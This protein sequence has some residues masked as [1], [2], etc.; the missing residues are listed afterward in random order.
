MSDGSRLARYERQDQYDDMNSDFAETDA[1]ERV[2]ASSSTVSSVISCAAAPPHAPARAKAR[3]RN[4]RAMEVISKLCG[5]LTNIAKYLVPFIIDRIKNPAVEIEVETG[6]M[7]VEPYVRKGI[8]LVVE[9]EYMRFPVF[10]VVV[11]H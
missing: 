7:L 10:S 8:T 4:F 3:V 11:L 1:T 9:A 2:R 6:A 5:Y